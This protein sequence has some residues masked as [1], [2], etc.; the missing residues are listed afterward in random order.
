MLRSLVASV[1]IGIFA[2][3]TYFFSVT[4]DLPSIEKV[5]QNGVSPTRYT[6]VFAADGTPILSYGK[7]HHENVRLADVSHYFTDALIATEDRRFY[8]HHGVDPVAVLRAIVSDV[9]H[10]KIREGGSTITQQLARNVFLS[11]ERSFSRKLR[12]AALAMELEKKLSKEQILEL[13][14]NNT[15]FGEGA[16]GIKAASEIYFGKSPSRLTLDEAALL[17]G[18]PQAPS[19]YSPFQNP[20]AAVARRNEVLQNLVEVGKLS[21]TECD[22]LQARR[23]HLNRNGQDLASS[24]KAPFFNRY[25]LTQVLKNFNLDEQSFWQSGLKVY[26]TLDLNAQQLAVNAV[27]QQ[28]ALY[29]RNRNTQQAA[30]ISLNPQTGAILAYVGGKNYEQSQFDRVSSATRS[31]GSLFKIFTYTAA[32]DRGYEP[33]RV[34]LDEPISIN[35]WTPQNYDRGHHGY[36]TIAHA[37]ITSNNM[38]AVKVIRELGADVVIQMAQQMGIHSMLE[39]YLGLTLGGSGVHPLEI[40]SAFGVLANQGVRVEPYA[41][42]R[43]VDDSGREVYREHPVSTNVLNRTTV[44]TMV[45][46]MEAVVDR[47]TAK[48]AGIGR[49]V[50]G[51]TGTSDDYRDAW[52]VGFTP[53]VVTGVWVGNDNNTTMPGMTGGT[54]PAVIWRSYMKPYMANRPVQDFDLS[55][56]KPLS[57][58]DFTTFNLK[59]LSEQEPKNGPTETTPDDNAVDPNAPPADPLE[60]GDGQNN[61]DSQAPDNN[62]NSDMNPPA[63]P[64]SDR[65]SGRNDAPRM[66]PIVPVQPAPEIQQ[67]APQ[68]M[69]GYGNGRSGGSA[70]AQRGYNIIPLDRSGRRDN[71][72][73]EPAGD[74]NPNDAPQERSR[75][76]GW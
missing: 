32:I 74:S 13:Y 53:D 2:I 48:A 50:A 6:Q 54:L 40:T 26:T 21:Q 24:N 1:L 36:M 3:F 41:I 63:M 61:G 57:T 62:P 43:I 14:V 11:N 28:S 33:T 38:V 17:A 44:D 29:G 72:P 58:S 76:R 20:K 18:M 8:Q 65:D 55:Y 60:N 56:S 69:P 22:A 27:R 9:T 68:P 35:G 66:N 52:F 7:F 46:M 39:P 25:V 45:K 15:Y 12:E 64:T 59:N 67:Q 16:Y 49:P 71:I 5:L 42:T 70:S 30:L 47:G 23:L 51:K 4:R 31:P 10:K 19:G 73:V 75:T 37:L 34:Y